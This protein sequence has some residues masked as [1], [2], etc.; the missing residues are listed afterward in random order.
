MR[1]LINTVKLL[2]GAICIAAFYMGFAL[3]YTGLTGSELPIWFEAGIAL[4]TGYV[5]WSLVNRFIK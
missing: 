2:A 4:I 5:S 3:S 1:T